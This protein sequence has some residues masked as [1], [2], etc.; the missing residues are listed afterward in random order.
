MSHTAAGFT[1]SAALALSAGYLG[2]APGLW[3][4]FALNGR[5]SLLLNT[6]AE[7]RDASQYV[8]QRND[9]KAGAWTD[10]TGLYGTYTRGDNYYWLLETPDQ[11]LSGQNNWRIRYASDE[12]IEENWTSFTANSVGHTGKLVSLRR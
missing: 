5:L 1:M 11:S 2:A 8:L 6:T 12:D 10:V 7:Q 9:D 3:S 4:V